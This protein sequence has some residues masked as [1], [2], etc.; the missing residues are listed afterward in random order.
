MHAER[1]VMGM[2]RERIGGI[3]GIVFVVL[4][5]VATFIAPMPPKV[6]D[7]AEK[8]TAYFADHRG[9]ILLSGYLGG[10][11]LI[12]AVLF[13]AALYALLRDTEGMS[14]GLALASFASALITGVFATMPSVLTSALAFT[15][16]DADAATM[17]GIYNLDQIAGTFIWF[18]LV[19]WLLF[20]SLV[21]MRMG[22]GFR[23][24]GWLGILEAI[25]GL[26]SGAS[27]A[28]NGFFALGGIL[29]LIGLL[30][31]AIWVLATSILMLMQARRTA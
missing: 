26:F 15:G 7:S 4:V 14:G 5:I 20:A 31:F 3:G 13:I 17:R 18:P 23:W 10:L 29:G 6:S 11:A 30:I 25:V 1:A 27:L 21:M 24:V 19:A 16:R 22:S 9:V 28:R 12:P 2:S 8:I